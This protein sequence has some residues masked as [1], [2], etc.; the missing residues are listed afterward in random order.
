MASNSIDLHQKIFFVITGASRG[1]G[2]T[3]AIECAKK[4]KNESVIVLLA[5]NA[6]G[7]SD[8]KAQI[9]KAN[10]TLLVYTISIDLGN[11]SVDDLRTCLTEPLKTHPIEQFELAFIIHNV[12]TMSEVKNISTYTDIEYL[13]NYFDVNLF[14]VI[15][16]NNLFIDIFKNNKRFVVN[17]TS[18]AALSAYPSIGM[19]CSGK[20]ARTMYFKAIAQEE[21]DVLV[22]D[23]SPGPVDTDLL[24][25]V[26]NQ[27]KEL[28]RNNIK[29]L[30]PLE[31]TEK[32][33]RI[34]EKG[35][36]QSGEYVNFN[37]LDSQ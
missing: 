25:T 3:M 10:P 16:L 18:G 11:A 24:Q 9:L 7:L 29:I 36:Y 14:N 37:K 27:N 35:A 23:Y 4:F 13:R 26:Y 34:V 30:T 5:R 8:T 1:I 15:L 32:F 6:N 2:K 33:L 21:Q 17:L 22:L 28:P 19:Y 12:G 20:S 31:T